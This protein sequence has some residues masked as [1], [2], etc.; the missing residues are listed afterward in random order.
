M[1]K[2]LIEQ[3]ADTVNRMTQTVEGLEQSVRQTVAGNGIRIES[4]VTQVR[5]LRD[6]VEELGARFGRVSQQLAETQ[7]VLQSVDGRL[8]TH[9]PPP[10]P[11]GNQ[12]GGT[13]P[14]GTGTGSG[15]PTG[16]SAPAAGTLYNSALR[17]FNAGNYDLAEQQFKDYLRYYSE[18]EYGGNA[19]YYLGEIE[20]QRRRFQ[21]AITAYDQV[22]EDFPGSYKTAASYLKK[23]Y[24]MLELDQREKA[25]ALLRI[26][27][28]KF[29]RW[30]EAKLAR[31]RL[32]RLGEE[33]PE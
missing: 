32:K 1:L 15:T 8:A 19:Q 10:P 23:G 9:T 5:A 3:T 25:M 30:D 20:Y 16:A 33:F 26:V 29:P 12:P 11:Q 24:A 2:T 17:D 7:S 6:S 21:S 22:L 31:S 4:L 18:T 27:V 28:E 13:L 14:D